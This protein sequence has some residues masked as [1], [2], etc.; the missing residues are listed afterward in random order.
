MVGR[1]SRIRLVDYRIRLAW[2]VRRSQQLDMFFIYSSQRILRRSFSTPTLETSSL[3]EAG[4]YLKVL[5]LQQ[6]SVQMAS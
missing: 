3:Q 2:L 1:P 4:I 6:K 5:E